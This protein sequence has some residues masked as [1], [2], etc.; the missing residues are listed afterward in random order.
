MVCILDSRGERD[1][2]KEREFVA[3]SFSE[4]ICRDFL[5]CEIA[6]AVVVTETV[7]DCL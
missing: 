5:S 2:E 6:F 4:E 1:R 3:G 7:W